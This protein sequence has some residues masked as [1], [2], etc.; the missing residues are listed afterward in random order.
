[1]AEIEL[2][3]LARQCLTRRVA[4]QRTLAAKVTARVA[5]GIAA[6]AAVDRR[7]IAADARTKIK[8]LDPA[9]LRPDQSSVPVHQT[10][11]G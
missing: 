1:M 6:G 10:L 9:P 4:D 11:T 3:V 2:S 5:A 7:V 8:R